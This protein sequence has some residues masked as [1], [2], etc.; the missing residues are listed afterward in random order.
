[1]DLMNLFVKSARDIL[2]LVC[3]LY[4]MIVIKFFWTIF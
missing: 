2:V 4:K 1:M 3:I